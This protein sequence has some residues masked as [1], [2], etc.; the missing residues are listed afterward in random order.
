MGDQ[1][2][3]YYIKRLLLANQNASNVQ[4]TEMRFLKRIKATRRDGQVR[5]M[6]LGEI[7]RYSVFSNQNIAK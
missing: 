7:W 4:A 6:P 1:V 2:L 5:M 3:L